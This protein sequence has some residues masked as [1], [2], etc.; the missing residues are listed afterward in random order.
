MIRLRAELLEDLKDSLQA[1]K[2][3]LQHAIEL[4]HATLPRQ[5]GHRQLS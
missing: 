2:R 3:A 1:L 5:P 4:E